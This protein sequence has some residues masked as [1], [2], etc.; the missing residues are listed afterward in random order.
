MTN[1]APCRQQK[2]TN[3]N[4]AVIGV[5]TASEAYPNTLYLLNNLRSDFSPH[6]INIP[7]LPEA[8]GAIKLQKFR[9]RSAIKFITTHACV[10]WK[11]FKIHPW[12]CVYIPYPSTFLLLA[13]S[14]FPKSLRPRKIIAD[15]FIS[16]YD[17]IVNDR[18][19][20]SRNGY[21]SKL[22]KS[23]ERR[24]FGSADL[25]IVDTPQN[26]RFY[27]DTFGLPWQLF[28]PIPLSTN[29]KDYSKAPPFRKHTCNVLFVGTLIPLHGIEVILAA[30]KLLSHREEIVFTVVG[31]GQEA[32]AMET[33]INEI[34]NLI[35]ERNWMPPEKLAKYIVDSSICLGIFGSTPKADRVCPYKIY[36]YA[37]VGRPVI[38]ADSSWLKQITQDY[39]MPPFFG[40]PAGDSA[41]LASA[42]IRIAD[43][44]K[45]QEDMAE[46]SHRFY[47]ASLSNRIAY[48]Q[49][50]E[51]LMEQSAAC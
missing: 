23:A 33:S 35:W 13:W 32:H 40:V 8:G 30:A 7:L 42:I 51:C 15:A 34:S 45:L 46:A 6:E 26:A 4:F 48:S 49:F 11:A 43:N 10:L 24:A 3:N 18:Q 31:D 41:M 19:L 5:H 20:V 39:G 2:I 17:T 50:R 27:A 25:I 47:T 38:T 14:F 9:L 22:L 44:P 1:K 36:A 16:I 12:Q 28:K 21:F 29:E 37:S